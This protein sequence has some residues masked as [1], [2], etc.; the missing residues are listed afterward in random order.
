[1]LNQTKLLDSNPE[2]DGKLEYN[3]RG[4]F[5]NIKIRA[6]D[7]IVESMAKKRKPVLKI[8]DPKNP[9]EYLICVGWAKIGMLADFLGMKRRELQDMV[10]SNSSDTVAELQAILNQQNGRM[11][12]INA[13]DY[14]GNMFVYAF[15][16]L[17]HQVITFRQ[18]RKEVK[19]FLGEDVVETEFNRVLIWE[20]TYGMFETEL[21]NFDIKIKVTSG[22]NI[23]TAAIKVMTEM[24]IASCQNSVICANYTSIKHTANWRERLSTTL[25]SAV[26][27]A[28]IA[29]KMITAGAT[30]AMTLEVGIK[31]ITNLKLSIKDEDK[32]RNVKTALI[33]R[34]KHEFDNSETAFAL[35]QAL[36]FVG[37]HTDSD[38]SSERTLEILREKAYQ[39]LV[40]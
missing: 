25:T 27:I 32:I 26:E 10:R 7:L 30:K 15:S 39:V 3:L 36:S 11:L 22:R 31:Y 14:N 40:A 13:S 23:K 19:E 29:Q 17:K 6:S 18:V 33:N 12:Q 38:K 5:L 28:S 21:D 8:R 24:K 4:K 34:F 9:N 20:K 16:T 37:T 1:M 35:S 2:T